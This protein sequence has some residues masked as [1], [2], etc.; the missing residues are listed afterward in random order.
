MLA[1]PDKPRELLLNVRSAQQSLASTGPVFVVL[2]VGVAIA[3]APLVVAMERALLF[4]VIGVSSPILL[5]ALV[6]PVLVATSLALV[7]A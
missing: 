3:I 2:L 7:P 4:T 1:S 6:G 5:T